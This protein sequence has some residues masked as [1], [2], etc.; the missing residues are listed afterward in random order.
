[1]KIYLF[2]HSELNIGL[3]TITYTQKDII[4]IKRIPG[5]AWNPNEKVWLIP[6]TLKH[7]ELLIQTFSSC[8]VRIEPKLL[9]ECEVLQKLVPNK[10]ASTSLKLEN[11]SP[12]L[13]SN[14]K[15]SQTNYPIAI[16]K[17]NNTGTLQENNSPLGKESLPLVEDQ[18]E[19]HFSFVIQWS[20]VEEDKLK[21]ELKAR[22]YSTKTI[23][24]YVG[25]LDRYF[26]YIAAAE[27]PFHR[28]ALKAYSVFLLDNQKSP[29]YVNQAISAI[30]FYLSAVHQFRESDIAFIRPK[31][32]NKLPHVLSQ[33]EIMR[34]LSALQN[35]KHKAILFLTYSAGLRVSEVV[36][37]KLQDLDTERK[38]VC[39][40]QGK[41]RK[42]RLTLLSDSALTIVRQ[43]V[44][45]DRPNNWLFPGQDRKGHL[46][47]RSVQKTF[48]HAV[49]VAKITK[50]VSI[51]ALRHSFATHLLEGGTDLRYIQELLGHQSSRTTEKYTHVSVKDIR[52]IQSPLDQIINNT[53]DD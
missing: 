4:Q 8:S 43:Y 38:T 21:H 12:A 30:K 11:M 1:M 47:E 22:G 44:E 18:S 19:S 27:L 48:E 50:D 45:Q 53:I 3:Q 9:E 6:Y 52:R 37:L 13:S 7:M 39:I 34:L 51:H 49:V 24:A 40:R 2:K 29:A 46:T 28:S 36:R 20:Q 15:S 35:L 17:H 25:H 32:E 41:G 14:Q 16:E 23:K 33:S 26:R 42:D 31:K 10:T 5:K